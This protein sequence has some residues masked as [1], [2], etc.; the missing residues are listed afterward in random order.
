[1]QQSEL[2]HPAG[3]LSSQEELDRRE[4]QI[5]A[6]SRQVHEM[7]ASTSTLKSELIASHTESERVTRELDALRQSSAKAIEEATAA[8]TAAASQSS[9][10]SADT[11]LAEERDRLEMRIVHLNQSL[12]SLKVQLSQQEAARKEDLARREETEATA[13][14][15]RMDKE[16]MEEEVSRWRA[17]AEREKESARNLQLVLEEF[18]SGKQLCEVGAVV[19]SAHRMA[20]TLFVPLQNK[21]P[22]Y[23]E[24][25]AIT[26]TSTTRLLPCW[27]NTKSG[28][29]KPRSSGSTQKTRLSEVELWSRTSRRR[30]CS[31]AN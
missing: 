27:K 21:M 12:E 8:A 30:T 26:S 22:S 10:S 4:S 24:P 14:Q 20:V 6:L 16:Y 13:E 18:Q 2:Y 7:Q 23:N 19:S 9:T 11:A 3:V 31:L 15:A 25:L 5:E 17:V 1:M 29:R 28:L